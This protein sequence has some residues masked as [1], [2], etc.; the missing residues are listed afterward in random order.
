MNSTTAARINAQ[1]KRIIKRVSRGDLLSAPDG[2][3]AENLLP[4]SLG[5]EWPDAEIAVGTGEQLRLRVTIVIER[6][7]IGDV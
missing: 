6:I 1:A 4:Q 7:A 3:K 2:E 5:L